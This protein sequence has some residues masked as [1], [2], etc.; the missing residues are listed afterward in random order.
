MWSLWW[1]SVFHISSTFVIENY[2]IW[3]ICP[4]FPIYLITHLYLCKL[5]VIYLIFVLS[6]NNYF[7]VFLAQKALAFG[8]FSA[9]FLC[10]YDIPLLCLFKPFTLGFIRNFLLTLVIYQLPW[11]LSP[12]SSAT[13]SSGQALNHTIIWNYSTLNIKFVSLFQVSVFFFSTSILSSHKSFQY[14][15]FSIFFQFINLR[16]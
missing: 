7:F 12:S 14:L 5:M 16:V 15:H 6:S 10:S 8:K 4:F 9:W 11:S 1:F 3:N 13:Y 2:S